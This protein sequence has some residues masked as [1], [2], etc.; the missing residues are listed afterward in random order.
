MGSDEQVINETFVEV[1]DI[2]NSNMIFDDVK[3][4]TDNIGDEYP[5]PN[6]T[7]YS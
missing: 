7:H 3:I 6:L 2:N 1:K 5:N 4:E